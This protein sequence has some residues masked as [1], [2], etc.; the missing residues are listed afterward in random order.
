MVGARASGVEDEDVDAVGQGVGE[1]GDG[2][3]VGDVGGVGGHRGSELV[4]R[5]VED[6]LATA[7]DGDG[8]PV[9]DEASGDGE[10]ETGPAARDE[11]VSGHGSDRTGAGR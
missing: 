4:R 2:V 7:G 3:G 8:H 6:V 10:A 11:G 5:A 1:P 9:G